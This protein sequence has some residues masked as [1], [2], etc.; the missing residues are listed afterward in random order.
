MPAVCVTR[1]GGL[2][3]GGGAGCAPFP[4]PTEI[5]PPHTEQRARTPAAGT[6]AGSTRKTDRHSGQ[7]TF[8]AFPRCP[9][10][11]SA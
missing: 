6:F 3:V 1:G 7:L 11:S 8:I 5:T 2:A 4:A 10:D 9:A